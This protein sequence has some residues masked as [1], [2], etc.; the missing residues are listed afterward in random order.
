MSTSFVGFLNFA[1][2]AILF[3]FLWRVLTLGVVAKRSPNFAAAMSAL[4]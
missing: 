3:A 4:V 1:S 2:A